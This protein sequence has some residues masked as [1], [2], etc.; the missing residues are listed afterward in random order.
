MAGDK[1]YVLDGGAERE[2]VVALKTGH[3]FLTRPSSYA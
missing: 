2:P 3:A 1:Y